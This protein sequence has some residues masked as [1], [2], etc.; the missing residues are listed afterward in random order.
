MRDQLSKFLN[1]L[2]F[3]IIQKQLTASVITV[4]I[5]SALS[6]LSF[7]ERLESVTYRLAAG[8]ELPNFGNTAALAQG[9][10][11]I[12]RALLISGEMYENDFH[13]RSPLDRAT[14]AALFDKVLLGRPLILAVDL[15][16]SPAFDPGQDTLDRL[17]IEASQHTLIVLATPVPVESP[18]LRGEKL[19]WMQKLCAGG[20]RFGTPT[21]HSTDGMVLRYDP[22]AP[23][24]AQVAVTDLRA[25]ELKRTAQAPPT[26]SARQPPPSAAATAP[27]CT[28]VMDAGA[29]GVDFLNPL[30]YSGM[31]QEGSSIK[32]LKLINANYFSPSFE[33]NI[34]T[35]SSLSDI[36]SKNDLAGQVVFLGGIYGTDDRFETLNGE[37]YG[38]LVHAAI[39]YSLT[40]SLKELPIWIC[41]I[42]D[43]ILGVAMGW[44][45][46]KLWRTFYSH[47]S[48]Y[49]LLQNAQ[50]E[51]ERT[52]RALAFGKSILTL[53]GVVMAS[54]LTLWVLLVATTIA[55]RQGTQLSLAYSGFAM[56]LYCLN[57]NRK[58]AIAQ[59]LRIKLQT[60]RQQISNSVQGDISPIGMIDKLLAATS[61]TP[62]INLRD[63]I[64]ETAKSSRQFFLASWLDLRFIVMRLPRAPLISVLAFGELIKNWIYI[65]LAVFVVIKLFVK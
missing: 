60:L 65:V 58:E 27:A 55:L 13:Q 33:K 41:R 57:M 43:V 18:K 15:D 11:L 63:L 46:E 30:Y 32:R 25:K 53:L 4:A 31:A 1:R 7:F 52:L 20:V 50:T 17:L 29:E 21:L 35:I 61:P 37:L 26:H 9:Q 19:L 54:L 22:S 36:P 23:T 62:P 38:V 2:R 16:I 24:F 3:E 5:V 56:L 49:A 10:E 47:Q 64:V 40:H 34:S 14:L 48:G 59:D 44:L 6:G 28:K 45:F 8:I 42:V 51:Q 12:P 39:F